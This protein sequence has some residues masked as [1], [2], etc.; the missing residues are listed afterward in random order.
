MNSAHSPDE[1]NPEWFV[2]TP[3]DSTMITTA[4]VCIHVV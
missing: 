4:E 2:Q 3:A 1:S